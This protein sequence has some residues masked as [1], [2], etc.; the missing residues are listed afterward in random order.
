M[1]RIFDKIS[2][3]ISGTRNP[4]AIAELL[5]MRLCEWTDRSVDTVIAIFCTP[6]GGKVKHSQHDSCRNI[7]VKDVSTFVH[8][9][10]C[11]AQG[12]S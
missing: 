11:S 1:L 10:R 5:I 3:N 6:L 7:A 9:A 8:T 4:S 12:A 2:A